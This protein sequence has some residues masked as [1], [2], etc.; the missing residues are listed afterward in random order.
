MSA[1]CRHRRHGRKKPYTD[2]GV[3]RLPCYRC[4]KPATF[5]WTVCAD[6]NLFRPLCLSCDVALNI[7]VL[8]WMGDPQAK[9]K[10]KLYLAT[11]KP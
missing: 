9:E 2:I 10:V 4:G 8:Q 1:R 3:R 6:K 5:Q 11:I 7:M